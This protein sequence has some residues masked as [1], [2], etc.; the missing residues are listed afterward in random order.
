L[1]ELIIHDPIKFRYD[2]KIWETTVGRVLFNEVLPAELRFVNENYPKDKL[3]ALV[4][5][6]SR[7]LGLEVTAQLL[8]AVKDL[9]FEQATRS[10]LSIGVDD[11]VVPKEKHAI[12]DRSE[13]DL[14]KV[15]KAYDRGLMTDGRSTIW[16][17]TPGRSRPPRS[18]KR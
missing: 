4:D 7:T 11:V 18:K 1:G 6:C 15:H 12:L 10:G 5:T 13:R 8:D 14:K 17:S 3:V 9:G 2:G 16:S